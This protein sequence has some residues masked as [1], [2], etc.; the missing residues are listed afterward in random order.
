VHLPSFMWLWRIAAW[1]MGLTI[2]LFFGLAI[3]G[4]MLRRQRLQAG[5]KPQKWLRILHRG[6]GIALVILIVNLLAIGV[7]GTLGHYGSLGHSWHLPVGLAVVALAL[8]SAWSATRIH[9]QRPWARS[10]HLK[11][12]SLL[13]VALALVSLSGWSVVQKYMPP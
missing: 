13:F 9:P 3:A 1:S 11:I 10:L 7:V 2:T 4:L 8:G 12:N 5:V 6:L